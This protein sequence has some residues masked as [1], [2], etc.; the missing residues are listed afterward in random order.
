MANDLM[1][2]ESRQIVPPAWTKFVSKAGDIV[3][4]QKANMKSP[5]LQ[6]PLLPR[7]YVKATDLGQFIRD[8][9]V[10]DIEVPLEELQPEAS[11]SQQ[12]LL[13]SKIEEA[14]R[15]AKTESLQCEVLVPCE[16]LARIAKD[17]IRMSDHEP[18]GLK[19]CLIVINLEESKN[20]FRKIGK[21]K[22]DEDTVAT[23]ELHLTLRRDL[24]NWLSLKQLFPSRLLK[25]IG[26]TPTL[27]VSEAYT[28]SKKKLYR[29][30]SRD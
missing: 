23:F 13:A 12:T 8:V 19:G 17:I 15:R 10:Q 25:K 29:S 2:D 14:L 6:S 26:R 28:L 1:S 20:L 11:L 5:A 27:V 18:C 16:L 24:G 21:L 4:N 3:R 22:F 7:E 30:S 9:S